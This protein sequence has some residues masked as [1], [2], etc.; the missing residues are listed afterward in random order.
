VEQAPDYSLSLSGER[1]SSKE[2]LEHDDKVRRSR[3]WIVQVRM[4]SKQ[5]SMEL[6]KTVNACEKFCVKDAVYFQDQS[7]PVNGYRSIP[8]IQIILGEL[9]SQRMALD[10]L[11]QQ[12]DSFAKEVGLQLYIL[13]LPLQLVVKNEAYGH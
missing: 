7:K 9:E 1:P 3:N 12:C 2:A 13:Q 10:C 11:A 6:S 5:L 4:L 8:A